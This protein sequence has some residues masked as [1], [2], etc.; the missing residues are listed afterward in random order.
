MVARNA[1]A[2]LIIASMCALN[3]GA[4]ADITGARLRVNQI[5]L[6][7]D[8]VSEQPGRNV[9]D[10]MFGVPGVVSRLGNV[11]SRQSVEAARHPKDLTVEVVSVN[12]AI[13]ARFASGTI[14]TLDAAYPTGQFQ[15]ESR[16]ALVQEICKLLELQTCEDPGLS[17][18][19]PRPGDAPLP[20]GSREAASTVEVT[21]G[22]LP[23][24]APA[25]QLLIVPPGPS[26][27]AARPS[28]RQQE[29]P[30]SSAIKARA[31]RAF[32]P[33]RP[34]TQ[35]R[36]QVPGSASATARTHF[37]VHC[38]AFAASDQRMRQW[39][40]NRK[41]EGSRNKSHGVV[42]PSGEY[43]P[44]WPFSERRVWATKTETCAQTTSRAMGNLLNIELHYFCATNRNDAATAAQYDTV[45]TI[46]NEVNRDYGPLAIVSHREV[47]R[48]LHDGHNDP[49]GFNFEQFYAVLQSKGVDVAALRKISDRRHGLRTGRDISHHFAPQL[50][51]DIVL[52]RVRR[53]DCRRDQ[54][55][56]N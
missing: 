37:V 39:V 38:T 24:G 4:K 55:A 35:P 2:I 56:P 11:L 43:L 30:L 27:R 13:V 50:T 9:L 22:A 31:D 3:F 42:L 48:G 5:D 7:F 18:R 36:S 20:R 54:R 32:A 41:D 33:K 23:G 10:I 51:G 17:E 21:I 28:G 44:M 25:D 26:P 29:T 19:R 47:D 1:F 6:Q 40:A 53:D 49:I 12:D 8:L 14:T 15:P 16:E 46:F 34:G 45:A 52:E